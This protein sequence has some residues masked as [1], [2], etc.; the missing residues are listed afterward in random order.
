MASG[1]DTAYDRTYN[2]ITL[3]RTHRARILDE[4]QRCIRTECHT[5]KSKAINKAVMDIGMRR[6]QRELFCLCGFGSLADK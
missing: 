5:G 1:H 6:Y 2:G 4:R 3:L